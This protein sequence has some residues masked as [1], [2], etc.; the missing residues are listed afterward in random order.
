MRIERL[1][2]TNVK[3]CR[4]TDTLDT[5]AKLMWDY[6]IGAVAITDDHG[7][8]T[9]II[10]DRDACMAAY[11]Q[12]APLHAIT[13]NVAMTRDLATCTATDEAADVARKMARYQVR[14]I[15]VIDEARHPIGMVT[16][17]DLAIAM[18]RDRE[19]RTADVAS[20]L[21]AISVHRAVPASA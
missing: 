7:C 9:G 18:T 5:A 4:E 21:A 12:Y 19:I 8:L 3:T 20:V 10:T 14:R 13:C 6:D 15:P 16:L 17:N 1:M 11:T 2:T